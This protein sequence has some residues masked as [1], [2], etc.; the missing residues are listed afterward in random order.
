[1]FEPHSLDDI[2]KF[3]V[4]AEIIGVELQLVSV[5]Q[6]ARLVNI[7]NH[8]R[9]VAFIGHA[10]VTVARRLCLEFDHVGHRRPPAP[11]Q[12]DPTRKRKSKD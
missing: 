10:P 12:S 2:G 5:E 7:H 6:P 3:D 8:A 1:M 11:S 9:H 4:D